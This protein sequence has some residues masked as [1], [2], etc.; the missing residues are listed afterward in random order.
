MSN[1]F[2]EKYKTPHET[3]P[4]NEIRLEHF[5]PAFLEGIRRSEEQIELIINNPEPPT[6]DNTIITEQFSE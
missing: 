6:F 2:F 3:I 4:F 1:P 5:E